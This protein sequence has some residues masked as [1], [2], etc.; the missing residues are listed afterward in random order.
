VVRYIGRHGTKR[1]ATG[2]SCRQSP[3][4]TEDRSESEG[5]PPEVWDGYLVIVS[6]TGRLEMRP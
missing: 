6:E 3:A 1:P 2:Y 5:I 4:P